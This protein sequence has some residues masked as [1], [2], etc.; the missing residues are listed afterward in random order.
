MTQD[1]YNLKSRFDFE[2]HSFLTS[3]IGEAQ[4]QN[5]ALAVKA[6]L[7][8]GIDI[9]TCQKVCACFTMPCRFEVVKLKNGKYFIKDGAHN[10]AA[11]KELVKT[12]KYRF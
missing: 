11:F 10:P 1:F 5:A 3:L 4:N 7:I 9:K 2:N 6:A 8:L 12:Y